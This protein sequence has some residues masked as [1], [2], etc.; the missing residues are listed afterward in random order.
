MRDEVKFNLENLKFVH[1]RLYFLFVGYG[2]KA[3]LGVVEIRAGVKIAGKKLFLKYLT[4]LNIIPSYQL[5]DCK[6]RRKVSNGPSLNQIV[7][8]RFLT[9]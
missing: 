6:L 3:F 7:S 9:T 4:N 2:W 1:V 5:Q 8:N